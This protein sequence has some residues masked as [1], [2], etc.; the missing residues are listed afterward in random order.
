MFIIV[1]VAPDSLVFLQRNKEKFVQVSIVTVGRGLRY[2]IADR[3][4]LFVV[5][6]ENTVE[7]R[8]YASP[9]IS[10]TIC[11][12]DVAEY[13]EQEPLGRIFR[14]AERLFLTHG[15]NVSVWS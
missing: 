5:T 4:F 3:R 11:E 14:D 1:A 7:R 10:E 15:G 9:A 13:D 12:A 8:A 2:I 6:R